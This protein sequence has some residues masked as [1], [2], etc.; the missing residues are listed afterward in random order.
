MS[1]HT[2]SKPDPRQIDEL[3]EAAIMSL[4]R[5][6]Q[7]VPF[8]DPYD[9]GVPLAILADPCV[10]DPLAVHGDTQ[11]VPRMPLNISDIDRSLSPYLLILGGAVVNERALNASVRVAVQ[12]CLG[13]HDTETGRPRSVCAWL[14]HAQP[15]EA[16]WHHVWAALNRRAWVVPPT[17]KPRKVVRFWDPRLTT[18]LPTTFGDDTWA[19][20]LQV[21][22]VQQWWTLSADATL[23]RVG[24]AVAPQGEAPHQHPTQANWQLDTAQW[25]GLRMLAWRNVIAQAATGWQLPAPPQTQALDD[26]AR[27]AF[28]HGLR[29]NADMLPFAHLALTVHPLFD[30]HPQVMR[31]LKDWQQGGRVAGRLADG[32]DMWGE[33]FLEHL[34]KGDWL[35]DDPPPAHNAPFNP[36]N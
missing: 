33:D 27:R 31:A 22:G 2:N 18:Q 36:T 9:Y 4:R 14:V 24:E 5:A 16:D 20:C 21:L 3:T 32:I 12:E 28:E 25:H 19:E 10:H 26:I 17:N 23:T 15:Q 6:L 30:R 7:A 11:A 34:Q 35:H 8:D 29:D 13:A 1:E